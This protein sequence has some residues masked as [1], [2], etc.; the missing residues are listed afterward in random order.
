V[1]PATIH[2]PSQTRSVSGLSR[3]SLALSNR[4]A[5]IPIVHVLEENSGRAALQGRA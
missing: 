1:P 4:S 3:K 2:H 5:G